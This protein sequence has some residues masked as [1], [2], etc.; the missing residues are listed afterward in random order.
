MKPTSRAPYK[1]VAELESRVRS[2]N[3]IQRF[4]KSPQQFANRVKQI[5]L[6]FKELVLV[7]FGR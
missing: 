3:V 4:F 1:T 2:E 5:H 6:Y 7:I